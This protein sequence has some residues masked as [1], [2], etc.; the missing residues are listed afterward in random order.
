MKCRIVG[1]ITLFIVAFSLT[2]VLA[3][4]DVENNYNPQNAAIL[5]LADEGILTGY[6]DNC[7]HP[8][9]NITRAEMATILY[10]AKHGQGM[11]STGESIFS[12]TKS[13]W[14]EPYINQSVK[15]GII[16][17][18]DN[19]TFAPD[20]NLTN[21]QA[22]KMLVCLKGLSEEAESRGGYPYGYILTAVHVGIM[23]DIVI[24]GSN[25]DESYFQKLDATRGNIALMLYNSIKE[26]KR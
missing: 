6:D 3:F 26:V 9:R 14:A 11:P 12:D 10:R 23:D 20:A 15:D 1:I 13:H 25:D 24:V 8:E 17:G 4:D 7:F 2:A 18:F 16:N 5:Y 19:N 21:E 22:L